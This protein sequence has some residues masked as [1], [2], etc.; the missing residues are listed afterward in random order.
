MP[1]EPDRPEARSASAAEFLDMF[2]A[3]AP[4]A[5]LGETARTTLTADLARV[6][7]EAGALIHAA[8][9]PVARIYA[10]RSGVVRLIAPGGALPTAIGPGEFFGARSLLRSGVAASTAEA[11]EACALYAVP[12]SAFRAVCD[13]AP[14]FAAFFDHA[15]AAEP[16]RTADPLLSEKIGAL[17]T[18]DPVAVSPDATVRA[19]AALIREHDISCL[20][21]TEDGRLV[22]ILT[23]GDLAD[24][25]LAEGLG[26]ETPVRAAMTPDPM[27]VAP[28]ALAFDALV[29]MT[30]RRISHLPVAEGGRLVGVL[31]STNLVQRQASSAVFLVGDIAK[32]SRFEDFAAIVARAPGVLAQMVGGGASAYDVGRIMTT[33]SDALTR[34]LLALAEADLGPAPVGWCWAACG[35]QGRREQ[36]GVSDQDNCLILDDGYDEAEHG[37]YFEKLARFVSDGLDAA[38]YVYCPGDMMATNPRWRQPEAVWRGYFRKWIGKPD[39][40]AQMLASVMFDLRAIAGREELLGRLQG[41]T[42]AAAR[43][44]SIFRAHMV[45][46]SLKHQPPLG[47]FRGLSLIRSGEHKD[48]IDMKHAGVVPVVD[49]ARLYALGAG[50]TAVNTRERLLAAKA[51]GVISQAGARDLI[52]AYDLIA[53]ARLRHQARLIRAGSRPDNFMAP[54]DLSDLERNHLKD[55]FQVIK[56]M[57]AAAANALST[58]A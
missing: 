3:R 32:R 7:F 52:D 1:A 34:R 35:S 55:A 39:D 14:G 5:A 58:G 28:D 24:R 43:K 57:Q 18:P 22:G 45:R 50:L 40:E 48:R 49:L 30:E 44:N 20:P 12:A 21:V 53:D 42:L 27:T 2:G 31:T 29:L 4:F 25:V 8:G 26:G 6:E 37:A 46:N 51:G 56:T 16:G 13:A 11:A 23:T 38:G 54:G 41:E 36:T 33:V 9:E 15:R 10:I 17:M 19:A 47:L